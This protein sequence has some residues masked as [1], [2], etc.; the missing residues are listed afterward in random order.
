MGRAPMARGTVV[1]Q[2]KGLTSQYAPSPLLRSML[3]LAA[4]ACAAP[5]RG[6][7][8]TRAV[9]PTAVDGQRGRVGHARPRLPVGRA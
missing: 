4:V 8:D 7:G 9:P 1:E 6:Q 2:V 3:I 5:A